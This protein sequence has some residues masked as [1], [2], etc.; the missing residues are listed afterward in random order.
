[1][2]VKIRCTFDMEFDDS[3]KKDNVHTDVRFCLP[4]HPDVACPEGV[5]ELVIDEIKMMCG[6]M[7]A[8]RKEL[9]SENSQIN[10]PTSD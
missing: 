9:F 7:G 8:A 5:K 6:A 3:K 2:K 1:M 4:D 10:K